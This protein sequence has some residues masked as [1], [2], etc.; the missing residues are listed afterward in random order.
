[1]DTKT[2]ND[3]AFLLKASILLQNYQ[4]FMIQHLNLPLRKKKK[5]FSAF[6]LH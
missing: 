4:L 2:G 3:P 6:V 1:M 5:N